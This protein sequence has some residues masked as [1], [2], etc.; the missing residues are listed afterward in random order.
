MSNINSHQSNV[1]IEVKGKYVF[2]DLGVNCPFNTHFFY[3]MNGKLPSSKQRSDI[4]TL[5]GGLL[6]LLAQIT[7][8]FIDLSRHYFDNYYHDEDYK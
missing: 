5:I 6:G 3:N 2:W 1:D 4:S 8:S 7:S